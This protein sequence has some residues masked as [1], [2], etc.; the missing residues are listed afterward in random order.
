MNTATQ[1][2]SNNLRHTIDVN[3]HTANIQIKIRLNDECKNGHQDFSITA[4]IWETGKKRTDRNMISGGC[5]HDDILEI[6]PDLKPFVNLHLADYTG[7]PMYAVENGFYHLK[8]G[9]NNTKTTDANFKSEFCEYYRIN[10]AQFDELSTSENQQRYAL[11]LVKLGVLE[12]WKKEADAAILQMEQWT[13][14]KFLVDSKRT[15]F[16]GLTSEQ[17]AEEEAKEKAGYYTTENIQQRETEKREEERRKRYAE[18]EA[19]RDKDI[20]KAQIEYNAKKAV[21]DA[22]LSLENFIFYNH[23]KKGSFNWKNYGKRTTEEEFQNFV[24]SEYSN[25]EG[26]TW[27]FKN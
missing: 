7:C 15:Q 5:C 3:N 4:T 13:G 10:P 8:H 27:E 18:I 6:R 9:F 16:N 2:Q 12:Q 19:E 14:K 20:L 24:N 1:E 17:I 11:K 21:L 23:T 25:I 26:I 22:G